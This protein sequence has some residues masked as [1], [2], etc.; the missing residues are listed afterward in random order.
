[1]LAHLRVLRDHRCDR[2]PQAG[3]SAAARCA[4]HAGS[5]HAGG[6]GDARRHECVLGAYRRSPGSAWTLRHGLGRRRR[7]ARRRGKPARG[8]SCRPMAASTARSAAARW[9]GGRSPRRS[10]ACNPA[11]A[12]PSWIRQ[13]LGPELGQCCGG[14]VTLLVE[15][16][17]GQS[18]VQVRDFAAREAGG[19]FSCCA[20]YVDGRVDRERLEPDGARPE[21]THIAADGVLI[22]HFG[23][24][25]RPIYLFGA[26][27]V[28]RALVLALAPLPLRG[29]LDRSA[30]RGLSRAPCRP[31]STA[32]F[33]PHPWARSPMAPAGSFVL[34]MTHSHALDLAITDAA[35][36]DGRFPYVGLIGSGTKRAR[37]DKRLRE[38]GIPEDRIAALVCPIG[39]AGIGGKEPAVIA[40]ATAAELLERD[41]VV[42]QWR[43][44]VSS[45]RRHSGKQARI[46]GHGPGV[47]TAGAARAMTPAGR[48]ISWRP[49]DIVKDFGALRANDDVTLRVA[50]G[51]IHALAGRERRRQVDAGQ[52]HLWRAAA[53]RRASSAGRASR[54][55]IA[56]PAAARSSASAWCSS[57]SRCSRR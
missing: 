23:E 2:Q 35:L 21:P 44:L 1:M 45:A 40:A 15:V 27:H 12:A 8:W 14:R 42:R 9:N 24:T 13:S 46:I 4:G 16:F 49:C 32:S 3:H 48:P 43:L 7:R 33:R 22:E 50:P 25:R 31:M 18:L 56:N 53:R 26:G 51:E 5:D 20:Q 57:I 29:H 30:P 10:A 11:A 54:S 47:G 36:A 19:G 6:Q 28:G 39:I 55:H 34:V 52:D 41:E 37:F 38:V 17:D